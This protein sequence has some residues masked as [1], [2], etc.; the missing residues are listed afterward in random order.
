MNIPEAKAKGLRMPQ[1]VVAGHKDEHIARKIE[2]QA[3]RN[4][5]HG[6]PLQ[7]DDNQLADNFIEVQQYQ[8]NNQQTFGET[9]HGIELDQAGRIGVGK[10]GSNGKNGNNGG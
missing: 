5:E 4:P 1:G 6:F 3:H 10:Q 8:P 7:M 9:L 2:Q